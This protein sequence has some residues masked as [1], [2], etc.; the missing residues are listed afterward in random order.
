MI[1]VEASHY[2]RESLEAIEGY[3]RAV[4]SSEQ[5]DLHHRLEVSPDGKPVYTRKQLRQLDLLYHRPASELIFLPHGEHMA[6]HARS[7]KGFKSHSAE[8]RAKISA[9]HRGMKASEETKALLSAM[10]R[11]KKRGPMSAE[12]CESR[13]ARMRAQWDAATPE[14]IEAHKQKVRNVWA[15]MTPEQRAE[16]GRKIA[17][18]RRKNKEKRL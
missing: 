14:Q 12:C 5:W 13:R 10:R 16:R 9:A 2:C 3:E 7:T 4:S 1:S 6:L 18:A 11:G 15:S 17:E 8:T